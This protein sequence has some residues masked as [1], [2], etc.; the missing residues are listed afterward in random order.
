MMLRPREIHLKKRITESA[1][2]KPAWCRSPAKLAQARQPPQR[3]L[4]RQDHQLRM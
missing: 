1:A 4:R 2:E 3:W